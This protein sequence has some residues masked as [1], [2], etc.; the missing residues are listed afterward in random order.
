MTDGE[1]IWVCAGCRSVNNLR[2]K[3]CYNCR[4]PKDRAAVDPSEVDVTTSGQIREIALPSFEPSRPYAVVASIL[5][6]VIGTLH[7]INSLVGVTFIVRVADGDLLSDAEVINF[8][9]VGLATFGIALIALT[10]W[11]FW[12]S[13]AVRTMPALGLGYPPANGLMAFVENFV[14]VLNLWRVPAIV[15]DIAVRLEP[16]ESRGGTL[17]S[18]AWVGLITGYLLPR[19]GGFV[20]QLGAETFENYVRNLV[21]IQVLSLGLVLTGSI[22]LVVLIW[23]I[24]A[25]IS[26]RQAALTK[27]D[28]AAVP[29]V[30]AAPGGVAWAVGGPGTTFKQPLPSTPPPAAVVATVPGPLGSV[31]VAASADQTFSRP[32]TALTGTSAPGAVV[33]DPSA[34]VAPSVD[35]APTTE[36]GATTESSAGPRLELLIAGDGSMV[37]TLDGESE[38]I[39]IKE[40]RDAATVLA[41]VNGSAVLALGDGTPQATSVA[42]QALQIFT[43]AGV[44][45][46]IEQPS[47]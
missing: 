3:Q 16:G 19:F 30:V 7:A 23:W 24:E 39:T 47:R 10:G 28:P 20:N 33:V 21:I 31:G 8:G 35:P 34:V 32:I 45:A 46:A 40:L 44:R 26:R 6:L 17:I 2:A 11:A 22:L 43:D 1:A 41:R 27:A 36:A 4:T 15:R 18:A 29:G 13:K 42:A 14:P 37:A 25:R 12:L 38:P 5:I 9:V